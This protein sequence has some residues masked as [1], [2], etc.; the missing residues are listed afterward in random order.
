VIHNVIGPPGSGKTTYIR[1]RFGFSPPIK[2]IDP[3]VFDDFVKRKVFE[4]TGLNLK[5]NRF[6]VESEEPIAT[7]WFRTSIP[8]CVYRILKDFFKGKTSLKQT[9]SRIKILCYYH[10]NA[11]DIYTGR[12]KENN[13]LIVIRTTSPATAFIRGK[14]KKRFG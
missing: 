11:E 9:N 4:H 3:E 5:I 1:D 6:L 10:R 12:D 14:I 8:V 7:I 13:D 2:E